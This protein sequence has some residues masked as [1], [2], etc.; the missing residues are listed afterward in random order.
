MKMVVAMYRENIRHS[1]RKKARLLEKRHGNVIFHFKVRNRQGHEI[2]HFPNDD[3]Y[4]EAN[5]TGNVW[6]TYHFFD[7]I[8][9]WCSQFNGKLIFGRIFKALCMYESLRVIGGHFELLEE[10]NVETNHIHQ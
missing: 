5:T 8:Q 1:R 9:F 3:G 4:A 10:R 6:K 2:A 7:L